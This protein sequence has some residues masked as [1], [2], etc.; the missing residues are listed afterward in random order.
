MQ[1]E[2]REKPLSASGAI[3][4]PSGSAAPGSTHSPGPSGGEEG[5][6]KPEGSGLPGLGTEPSGTLAPEGSAEVAGGAGADTAPASVL[7][8][9][10][11]DCA[12]EP[13]TQ[14]NA[15]KGANKFESQP[16]RADFGARDF[17][18]G[19]GALYIIVI[20]IVIIVIISLETNS[21][22]RHG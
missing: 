11:S 3:G 14:N 6:E 8:H 17:A 20:I 1:E 4:M 21:S 13:P 12:E 7:R 19:G 2:E 16:G 5:M 10:L 22:G 9:P 18:R 15:A